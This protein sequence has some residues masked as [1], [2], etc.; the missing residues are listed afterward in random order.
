M[1]VVRS[2]TADPRVGD[3]QNFYGSWRFGVSGSPVFWKQSKTACKE[4]VR[5]CVWVQV[6]LQVILNDCCE[7]VCRDLFQ[8]VISAM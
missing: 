6:N 4:C 7:F 3:Q 8:L 5:M 1:L 2:R